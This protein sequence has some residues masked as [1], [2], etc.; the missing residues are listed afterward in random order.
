MSLLPGKI[1]LAQDGHLPV[2]TLTEEQ[3]GLAGRQHIAHIHQQI[4]VRIL[5]GHEKGNGTTKCDLHPVSYL[6]LRW[7]WWSNGLALNHLTL[8]PCD[9]SP[10]LPLPLSPSLPL[11]LRFQT[12]I[13]AF[14]APHT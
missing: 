8:S 13:A 2:R 10:C 7:H 3:N 1:P 14:S 11:T 5:A 12:Q 9:P 6:S 4:D